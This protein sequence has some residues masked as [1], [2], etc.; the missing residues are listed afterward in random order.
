MW[1]L[2][3]CDVPATPKA[4]FFNMTG[5]M[6]APANLTVPENM[7]EV[8]E[9]AVLTQSRLIMDDSDDFQGI[10]SLDKW[11]KELDQWKAFPDWQWT[12]RFTYQVIEKRGTG[13][14]GFRLMYADFLREAGDYLPAI[15]EKRPDRSDADGGPGL[16]GTGL[17]PQAGIGR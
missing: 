4:D 9:D 14:G 3:I 15:A 12:T 11:E 5:D 16:A 13:G 17:Y 8:V 2:P 7:P 1:R 6:F 10:A